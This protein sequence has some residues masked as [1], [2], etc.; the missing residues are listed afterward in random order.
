LFVIVGLFLLVS[1]CFVV[2]RWLLLHI[3]FVLLLHA[4]VASSHKCCCYMLVLFLHVG[5]TSLHWC[6]F[7]VS[8]LL[9]RLVLLHTY[10]SMLVL[11]LCVGA[12]TSYVLHCCLCNCA[13]FSLHYYYRTNISL[14]TQR[15]FWKPNIKIALCW[16]F[17]CVSD[18]KEDY[19][20]TP[21]TMH[22]IF[23]YNSPILNL[24]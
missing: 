24:S 5:A 3:V 19:L 22:C 15:L 13:L 16:A 17:Y 18:N 1:F 20:I 8:V 11:L 21:Q 6:Y 9:L 14:H 4:S 10:C 2:L 12:F 23:Y 7:L